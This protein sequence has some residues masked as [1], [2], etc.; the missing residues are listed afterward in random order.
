MLAVDPGFAKRGEGCA[1]ASFAKRELVDCW[2]ERSCKPFTRAIV[3]PRVVVVEVPQFD[4]RPAGSL[5]ELTA[6]G[7]LLAG[8]YA[9]ASWPC[10]VRQ[11]TP[12]QWKGSEHKPTQHARLWEIL[13]PDERELLG[14]DATHEKILQARRK[15]ALDRWAKAGG[16]YYPGKW[17]VHNQ[18]DA[19]A[20]GCVELG[21]LAKR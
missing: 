17:L 20:L 9:G 21:R 2:F 4:G 13:T 12:K 8:L 19:V 6:E 10:V 7:L 3:S 15:G 14:G 16:A 11:R 18:L 5:I 1:L